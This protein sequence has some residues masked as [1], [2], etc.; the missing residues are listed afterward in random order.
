MK[1]IRGAP[2]AGKTAQVFR[3]F[4]A[5][6]EAGRA[7]LRIVVPT[8]TLVRHFQHELA[9]DGF[10]FSPHSVVSLNRFMRERALAETRAEL[11]PDG[12]LR[13]IVRDTLRRIRFP[14]FAEVA[15]TEGMTAVLID[16][17]ELFENAACT[18]DD[19]NAVR[20]LA[21]QARAFAKL[22]RAAGDAVHATGA[23]MRS[24]LA[25]IA[26]AN[27]QP[28]RVWLDG[29]LAFSPIERD[30]VRSLAGSCE[31][32]LTLTDS[33]ATDDLRKFALQLGAED[34]LLPG[35]KR[36]AEARLIEARALE[37]EADEIARRILMLHEQG[38]SF[39][40]I[41]VALR[42][43]AAYVSLLRGTFERF[44]IPAHF[45]FGTPLR[46][47]PAAIFLGGLITG[48]LNGWDHESALD[49]LRANPRWGR[50][51]DFDRFDFAVREAMPGRGA[52]ELLAL[53]EID[54]LREDIALCLRTEAWK[55]ALRT[56]AE[57]Q[58][59]FEGLAATLYRPGRLDPPHDHVDLAATRSHVAALR[60]WSGAIASVAPFWTPP[61]QPI[62]LDEFWR[63]AADAVESA[64]IHPVDDRANAVHVMSVYE[65][66]QW[67]LRSLFVC[68][69]TDRDFPRQHP[70]NLLFP[71][72]E[73]DRLHAAG[74]PVRKAADQ[75]REERWMFD[76]LK[77]RA[78]DSLFFTVPERDAAGKSVQRSRLLLD[79]AGPTER[80]RLCLPVPRFE[81][82]SQGLLGRVDTPVL[83]TGMADLHRRISLTALEDLSQCRFRFFGM[84]T[85]ALKGAP[86]RPGDRLT[87]RVT[88][89]ILHNALERWIADKNRDFVELFE[90]A[91]DEMCR[92]ERLP[93]GYKLEVERML[94]RQ[95]ARRVSANDLWIP[96]SSEAE[97]ELLLEFPGGIMVAC[98]IDR[99]DILSN[100]EC[101]I[102]DY[103]SS[104][105]ANVEKLVTSRT[106]LQGPLYAL[107]VRE[108]RHLNPVAM[109]YWAVRDDKPF[110]WG[111]I[112]G[113]DLD[114]APVPENW[115]D[116]ARVRTVERLTGFLRGEV[117]ARPE[118]TESCR[119]CDLK[120]ACRV[121]QQPVTLTVSPGALLD[122]G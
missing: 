95:I 100:N 33:P 89:S 50:S 32:T 112:P 43:S 16:T 46:K 118:E 82:A 1:L 97:V 51:A 70:Q 49:T 102:V 9:R 28:A 96:E 103:K 42:D 75:D 18:P 38:T 94:F 107:A 99:I 93:A 87:P 66:R 86:D 14:E 23:L 105:T 108:Q 29:F 64:V 36:K 5:A 77:T 58:T 91:F 47:H 20:K 44:G 7:D 115:A 56:P 104:K 39:R 27:K 57:W 61:G 62:S 113:A 73:I 83:Q 2:G 53:C 48:T 101:V 52:E 88:G 12:L 122:L 22:W 81:P 19:L 65:A 98:R 37:R 54:W 111:K 109:V 116:D 63:V 121:E 55:D 60:A 117:Y 6:L 3:Q 69:M 59:R 15:A 68:G 30:F 106:R 24:D 80:T 114:L 17:I 76:S 119:W 8:A 85:L 40:E 110:G 84:K 41:G 78:T 92:K 71:D 21:P 25:R 120:S 79:F 90:T 10:V 74:I 72:S 45:Y 35:F 34:R 26:S 31:V 67:D 13:A 11:V 4:K